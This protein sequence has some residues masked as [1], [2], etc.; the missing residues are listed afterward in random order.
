MKNYLYDDIACHYTCLRNMW[1]SII[2]LPIL[3]AKKTVHICSTIRKGT[4]AIRLYMKQRQTNACKFLKQSLCEGSVNQFVKFGEI[5]L[6]APKFYTEQQIT[7]KNKRLSFLCMIDSISCTAR[8][9]FF[10]E[11]LFEAKVARHIFQN[12]SFSSL[13]YKGSAKIKQLL[14]I[15]G[16]F[17]PLRPRGRIASTKIKLDL[18]RIFV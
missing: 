16:H 12:N 9:I 3:Q 4:S 17:G 10:K 8:E 11:A 13:K 5:Y 1:E 15:L 6:R 18:K 7:K 2:P 14:E